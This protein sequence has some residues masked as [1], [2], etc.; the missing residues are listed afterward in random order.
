MWVSECVC[1]CPALWLLKSPLGWGSWHP[2]H[3]CSCPRWDPTRTLHTVLCNSS[4]VGGKQPYR[5]FF[6]S[7]HTASHI[8]LGVNYQ[9]V[10]MCKKWDSKAWGSCSFIHQHFSRSWPWC[11]SPPRGFRLVENHHRQ[12]I[13]A[14]GWGEVSKLILDRRDV[15]QK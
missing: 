5:R 2:S 12:F 3:Q 1:V 4:W 8:T 9:Q 11:V 15:Y 10:Q 13:P 7:K 6:K 14:Y